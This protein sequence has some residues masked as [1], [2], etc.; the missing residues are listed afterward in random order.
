[1]TT[2]ISIEITGL[3]AV[4]NKLSATPDKIDK[5]MKSTMEESLNML[6]GATPS[7]P[8]PPPASKYKR[9]GYLRMSLTGPGAD[10]IYKIAGS[11]ADMTGQ[12]G[13]SLVYAKYVIDENRQAYMHKGRWW[14]MNSIYNATKDKIINLWN[15]MINKV[16]NS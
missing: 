4:V 13:T 3:D 15:S 16:V 2:P 9:T 6:R 12:F 11:G 5:V 1:M 10:S 7:Y 8:P 14:T